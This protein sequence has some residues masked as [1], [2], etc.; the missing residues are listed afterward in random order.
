MHCLMHRGIL[1]AQRQSV[2]SFVLG[3]QWGRERA[4]RETLS[5]RVAGL[6]ESAQGTW[7]V[8]Q[9]GTRGPENILEGVCASVTK[10]FPS[11]GSRSLKLLQFL[12]PEVSNRVSK[13][14]CLQFLLPCS[15]Q[16][17]HQGPGLA[18]GTCVSGRM[19]Q[20]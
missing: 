12:L 9:Q 18:L 11:G 1:P 8:D 20:Q 13:G 4:S 6:N 2:I 19:W 16:S 3:G 17:P 7:G 10:Q 14:G 15:S 5:H